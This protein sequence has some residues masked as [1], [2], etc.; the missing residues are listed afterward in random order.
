MHYFLIHT[1]LTLPKLSYR[2]LKNESTIRIIIDNVWFAQYT[3]FSAS[4]SRS[5]KWSSIQY[6]YYLNK[7]FAS[8]AME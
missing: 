6:E 3:S 1:I 5:Y 7:T 8:N 2:F 4:L